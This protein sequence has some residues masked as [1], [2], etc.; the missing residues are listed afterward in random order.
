MSTPESEGLI[1]DS[2][3]LVILLTTNRSR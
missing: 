2:E 3:E 1:R